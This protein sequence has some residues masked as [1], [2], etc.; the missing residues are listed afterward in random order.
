LNRKVSGY[1]PVLGILLSLT[2]LGI[3]ASQFNY[4]FGSILSIQPLYLALALSSS[5]ILLLLQGLRFRYVVDSF[6]EKGPFPVVES[7][8]IRLG[9]QFVAMTT[10]AYVGGEVA[11]AAWLTTRGVPGGA[12]LWLPYTEI[13]FDVISTDIIAFTAGIVA[14]LAS[15]FFLGSVLTLMS[16]VMLVLIIVVVRLARS[17]SVHVPHAVSF[18]LVRLLGVRRGGWLTE[19]G[20]KLLL[21]FRYASIA[22]FNRGNLSKLAWIS[23]Y[24]AA[25]VLSTAACLFFTAAGLG[26]HL[27]LYQASLAV[28]ASII[29]GNLPV[30]FGGSGL[31]EVGVYYYTSLVFGI[32]SWPLVFA[33]RVAS[34][35]LPLFITGVTASVALRK[36]AFPH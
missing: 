29:L 11:R 9:S 34:Y 13:I 2:I 17:E 28:F 16:A 21:E 4:N 23:L 35:V 32:S 7:L 14:L 22:T 6:T 36:Y 5:V 24:T 33:W 27:T 26:V 8:A 10:P 31:A 25:I 18:L 15:Q 30:T 20:N 12:A 3:V 19:R 1:L